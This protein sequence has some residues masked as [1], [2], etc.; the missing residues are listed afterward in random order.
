[1]QTYCLS[2]KKHTNNVGAKKV[3]MTNKVVRVKSRC[4]NCMSEKSRLLKQKSN[5]KSSWNNV[6]PKLFVY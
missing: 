3:T 2:Y 6:N 1:M 4:A 5:K